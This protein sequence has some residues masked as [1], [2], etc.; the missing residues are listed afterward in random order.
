MM[1]FPVLFHGPPW[2]QAPP[3]PTYLPGGTWDQTG[4]GIILS[5][6]PQ[7]RGVRILLECFLITDVSNITLVLYLLMYTTVLPSCLF[8]EQDKVDGLWKHVR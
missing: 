6:E 8:P 7:K 4:S 5:P 2:V 3:P 1:S